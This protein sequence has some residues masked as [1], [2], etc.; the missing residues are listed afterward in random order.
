MLFTPLRDMMVLPLY[1]AR[2]ING[3]GKDI[4]FVIPNI[5]LTTLDKNT[6]SEKSIGNE[7]V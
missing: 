1:L 4:E 6:G 3:W 2:E 7:K 5:M